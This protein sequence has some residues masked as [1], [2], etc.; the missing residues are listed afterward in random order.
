MKSRQFVCA[1]ALTGAASHLDACRL[2][3]RATI[4]LAIVAAGEAMVEEAA[5]EAQ[6]AAGEQTA[7]MEIQVA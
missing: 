4:S 1:S 2:N 7:A 6:E 3:L 5:Q